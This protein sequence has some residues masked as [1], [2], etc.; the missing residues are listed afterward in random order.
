MTNIYL[1]QTEYSIVRFV[2]RGP[3]GTKDMNHYVTYKL[4]DDNW[5]LFNDNLVQY[6]RNIGI[7]H[8]VNLVIY[9][10]S[11]ET[12]PYSIGLCDLSKRQT[13]A[14]SSTSCSETTKTAEISKVI[15]KTKFT[16][17]AKDLAG[18]LIFKI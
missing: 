4:I 1:F 13:S 12:R 8:R 11:M 18:F 3:G 2:D 17:H 15:Y 10:K 14:S 16:T 6:Q 9:R 5:I 7:V